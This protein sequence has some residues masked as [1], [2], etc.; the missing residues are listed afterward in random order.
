MIL[1]GMPKL[2]G[3]KAATGAMPVAAKTIH[4]GGVDLTPDAAGLAKLKAIKATGLANGVINVNGQDIPYDSVAAT[5]AV[6][7][8]QLQI[9]FP[10]MNEGQITKIVDRAFD[11]DAISAMVK[12]S[13]AVGSQVSPDLLTKKLNQGGTTSRGRFSQPAS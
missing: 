10:T 2:I 9:S 3:A 11:P 5:K 7:K 4:I 1:P 13:N 12:S 6:T 8:A